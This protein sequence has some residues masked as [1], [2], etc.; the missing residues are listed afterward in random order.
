MLQAE[1]CL[2]PGCVKAATA[3]INNMD[4]SVDPCVGTLH[5]FCMGNFGIY[6]DL[7]FEILHWY[8]Y[9]GSTIKKFVGIGSPLKFVSYR[10]LLSSKS[11]KCAFICIK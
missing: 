8:S 7:T 9:I 10:Y 4:P 11:C 2:T 3:L 5:V 1:Y 6:K